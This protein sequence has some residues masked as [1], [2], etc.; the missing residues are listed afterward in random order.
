MLKKVFAVFAAEKSGTGMIAGL[1]QDSRVRAVWQFAKYGA[2]GVMSTLVQV[3]VFYI[4]AASVLQCLNADDVAVKFLG[5]PAVDVTD[6]VRAWRAGVAQAAGF[7]VSNL[8]C[9]VMNR[10]FVF[11]PGRHRWYVELA[12]FY[13][14][15]VTAFAAGVALQSI[16]IH[17]LGWQTSAGALI[18]IVTSLMI[19]FVVRKLFIF[20]G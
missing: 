7:T 5:L 15:S 20:K 16:A 2:V 6:G 12:M 19:N 8:F 18:E 3:G 9:W 10:L 17:H 4:L 14:A 11:T 13:G 1:M